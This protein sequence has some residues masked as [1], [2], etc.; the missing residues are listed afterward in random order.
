MLNTDSPL[1]I[2]TLETGY[3][4][5]AFSIEE[6]IA[7]VLDRIERHSDPAVWISRCSTAQI[8]NQI[9]RLREARSRGEKLPLLGLPFAI[10]DNIDFTGLPTTA[11]CPD[12]AFSPSKTATAVQRLMDAGAILIGK[13]NLDQFATGLVGTRSPYGG[14]R[15]VF[16]ARFIS[17]GSSSGSAV[18]VAAG[19]VSF[20]LGTD[21]AGS[22]RVPAA[23]N[24]LVGFKPT[25]GL[26]SAAGVVPACRSLD[27]VSVFAL[28]CHDAA[29]VA[30]I[31]SGFDSADPYS[32]SP[33]DL[34]APR[35]FASSPRLGVPRA[36][37]LRFF[38]NDEYAQLY[39]AAI[40]RAADLGSQ[41]VEIDYE[42]FLS[43][44]A[45]LYQDAFVAERWADLR[46]FA[47][48]H[49]DSLL[50][51]TK[52]ILQS[53][54]R[55]DAADAF[56]A[57]HRLAA[58]RQATR[59]QWD[60]IDALLLPTAGTIYTHDQIAADPIALNS[61]LGYYT[62]FVNLL[63]LCAI[64]IPAGFT[65]AG[66]PFGITLIAPAMADAAL[67]E[68]GD[69]LH[70]AAGLPIGNTQHTL[71]IA[72]PPAIESPDV[73]LAVVGAHLTGQPLNHQLTGRAAQ[74]VRTCR[75]A[76]IYK[77]YAL[78]NTTPAKPGLVRVDTGGAAIE[79]EVWRLTRSAFGDFVR[80]VPPPLGIGTLTLDN[81]DTVKGFICEPI[82]L[83]NATDI[84]PL[85]GWRAYRASLQK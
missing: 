77:L 22:G 34:P 23:F 41:I 35:V 32:R 68:L 56:H 40:K 65:A 51:I 72:P 2:A 18:S 69:R 12:F 60:Q 63:D 82:A 78:A 37:Q 83:Q 59:A 73:L 19:L 30:S 27:C 44:A 38:G 28:T 64:A 16:D 29:R 46:G 15:N 66:L 74:L 85:G 4:S 5:N 81:G 7:L 75:T 84:T 31:A 1:D 52:Q 53:A 57:T 10:K 48:G 55:F 80:E 39:Q 45:L 8:D 25:R 6:V 24:N 47:T 17:G 21:T 9:H 50:P 14:C 71:S 61:N 36:D 33:D 62:N 13:T 70:R 49:P 43:A 3:Q 67:F 76:P 20:S 79:V 54:T 42:P 26:I 11:A 58:F